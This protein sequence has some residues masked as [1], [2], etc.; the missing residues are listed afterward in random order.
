M[1]LTANFWCSA[2]SN[3]LFENARQQDCYVSPCVIF[4]LPLGYHMH[5]G[6]ENKRNELHLPF[7]SKWSW[8]GALNE[9]LTCRDL[10][11]FNLQAVNDYTVKIIRT[12]FFTDRIARWWSTFSIRWH[13]SSK[14]CEFIPNQ[15]KNYSHEVKYVNLSLKTDV[16]S[17]QVSFCSYQ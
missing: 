11:L 3:S 1:F 12:A 5:W 15:L 10:L 17:S 2:Q 8:N 14:W 4:Q 6:V 16:N 7:H 9:K 13:S